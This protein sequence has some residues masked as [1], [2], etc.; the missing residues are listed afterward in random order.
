MNEPQPGPPYREW[1]HAPSHLFVPGATYFVTC[2]TCAK[3]QLFNTPANLD[4]PEDRFFQFREMR[5]VFHGVVRTLGQHWRR[6]VL[7]FKCDK[8]AVDD[9]F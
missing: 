4:P 5:M 6:T 3:A 8:I 7:S 2:G 1:A 9:D